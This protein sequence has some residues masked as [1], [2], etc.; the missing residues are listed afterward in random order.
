MKLNTKKYAQ[1]MQQH[2]LTIQDVSAKAGLSPTVVEWILDNENT[3]LATIERLANAVDCEPRDIT[4][5]MYECDNSIIWAHDADTAEVTLSNRTSITRLKKLV[6]SCPEECSIIAEN[7]D[8]S[9]YAKVPSAWISIRRP[10]Q[11]N[12]TEEQIEAMRETQ[13]QRMLEKSRV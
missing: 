5:I 7:R 13:R 11:M 6:E 12:Y 8:G 1:L 4:R 2:N 9:V 10:K 3:G